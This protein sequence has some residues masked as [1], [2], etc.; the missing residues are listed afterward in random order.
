LSGTKL[1]EKAL[2]AA[3]KDESIEEAY[4]HVQVS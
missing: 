1:F 3:A 2:A 4:L